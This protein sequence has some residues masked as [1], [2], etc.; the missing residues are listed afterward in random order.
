MTVDLSKTSEPFKSLAMLRVR[1]PFKGVVL[2]RQ[3]IAIIASQSHGV[4]Q[5]STKDR[6][7]YTKPD[8]DHA[9][10]FPNIVF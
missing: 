2:H 6:Q 5:I 10:E 1:M 9:G 7:L 4:A 3:L 8:L